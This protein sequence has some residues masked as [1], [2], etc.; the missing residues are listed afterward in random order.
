M[1]EIII[2]VYKISNIKDGRYYI[3]HSQNIEKRFKTH[4]Y[5]LK[6]IVMIILIFNILIINMVRQTLFMK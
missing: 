2:G 3:G 5:N 1:S 6:I 4:K